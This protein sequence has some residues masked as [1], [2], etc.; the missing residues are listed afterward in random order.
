MRQRQYD[1]NW[2][3]EKRRKVSKLHDNSCFYTED[4]LNCRRA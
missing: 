2:E 3:T 1:N 4:E